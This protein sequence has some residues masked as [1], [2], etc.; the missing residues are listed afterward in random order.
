MGLCVCTSPNVL[1]FFSWRVHRILIWLWHAFVELLLCPCIAS[2]LPTYKCLAPN[3]C[4]SIM[5]TMHVHI[6][7][8]LSTIYDLRFFV[9]ISILWRNDVGILAHRHSV[10]MLSVASHTVRLLALL[11]EPFYFVALCTAWQDFLLAKGVSLVYIALLYKKTQIR[12]VIHCENVHRDIAVIAGC[13][14]CCVDNLPGGL[15]VIYHFEV[16]IAST[17]APQTWRGYLYENV[18]R[19]TAV[20]PDAHIVVARRACSCHIVHV[21]FNLN[22]L[23]VIVLVKSIG[24]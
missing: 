11:C 24:W 8:F 7:L 23:R 20:P 10:A 6:Y 4:R 2:V 13:T 18:H 15:F 5:F 21:D 17:Q 1:L 16:W 9:G 3:H 14:H 22:M 19:D 12:C